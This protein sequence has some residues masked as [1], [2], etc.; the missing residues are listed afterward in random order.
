MVFE[1]DDV[2]K[3]RSTDDALVFGGTTQGEEAVDATGGGATTMD[4]VILPTFLRFADEDD[5]DSWKPRELERE[6]PDDEDDRPRPS[7]SS[8]L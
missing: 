7:Y 4:L 1:G 8:H 2:R 5:V 3:K 6:L